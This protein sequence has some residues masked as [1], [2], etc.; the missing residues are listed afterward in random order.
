MVILSYF[1]PY[2]YNLKL[3]PAAMVQIEKSQYFHLS[4]YY[5]KINWR[6]FFEVSAWQMHVMAVSSVKNSTSMSGMLAP[7]TALKHAFSHGLW[8]TFQTCGILV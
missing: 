7:K 8:T 1:I 4:V 6:N 3:C 2:L 5:L